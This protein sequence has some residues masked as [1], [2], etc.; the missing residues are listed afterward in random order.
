MELD[1]K[2]TWHHNQNF[3]LLHLHGE[4]HTNEKAESSLFHGTVIEKNYWEN[5]KLD[6]SDLEAM[7]IM[8]STIKNSS[9]RNSD[10]H[11]LLVT[12][13]T[14]KS[15]SFQGTD[16]S[17][18]TFS[19]CEF[20]NCDFGHAALKENQFEKCI[21][22]TPKFEGGT[23]IMNNFI[24]STIKNACLKNVF[25]YTYYKNCVF[26]NVI[27]EAYL[28]GHCYGLTLENLNELSYL[29]M[30]KICNDNYQKIC[31]DISN[32]YINRGMII[33][34]GL[35]YLVNPQVPVEK[36]IIKCFECVHYYIKDNQLV[37][38]EQLTFLNEIITILHEDQ[39]VSPLTIIYLINSINK[40]LD[41]PKNSSLEK[42][43]Q[44]LLSV[45]NS[46]LTYYYHFIDNLQE[47]LA[48][49]P[50][51]GNI[52]LQIT[53]EKKPSY[54]LVDIMKN[55]DPANEIY[56]T[57]TASGSFIEWLNLSASVLPYIDTL[58][59][60]LGIVIPIMFE[61]HKSKKSENASADYVVE[62]TNNVYGVPAISNNPKFLSEITQKTIDPI[63]Q[64]SV[65]KTIRYV[66]TNNLFQ[67]D[68]KHGYTKKNIR[69]IKV[70]QHSKKQ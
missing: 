47:H 63:L 35:L 34:K 19:E 54:R 60:L 32:V 31:N 61:V 55:I 15:V 10:M 30:G 18:C 25:Y 51:E 21:L 7:R 70:Q 12:H 39:S 66:I 29:F 14:F 49:L 9:F 16:M 52:E 45:K 24:Q 11:S 28:L 33:N 20:I 44:G 56:V 36:A 46:M 64:N 53:Y 26:Q 1:D 65:N 40:T 67:A 2:K 69:S 57:K 4:I 59:A 23:Y 42:A 17:D 43:A 27:M 6:N 3:S 50:L 41:L 22:D 38:K 58:L 13:T 48:E 37:Q 68:D 5:I 8:H 62:I